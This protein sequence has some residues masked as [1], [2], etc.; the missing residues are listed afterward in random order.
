M[1]PATIHIL[2]LVED[3]G[4]APTPNQ[5]LV[6][7]GRVT[8]YIATASTFAY[9]C[10][11][12][13]ITAPSMNRH[14]SSSGYPKDLRTSFRTRSVKRSGSD[15][16]AVCFVLLQV[17]GD[18]GGGLKTYSYVIE[19]DFGQ[20]IDGQK[21]TNPPENPTHL[22]QLKHHQHQVSTTTHSRPFP[23]P[24]PH[25][26]LPPTNPYLT[27]PIRTMNAHPI[28]KSPP[29]G[30]RTSQSSRAPP[31]QDPRT[32]PESWQELLK[33]ARYDDLAERNDVEGHSKCSLSDDVG[34]VGVGSIE[35][36]LREESIALAC[37]WVGARWTRA[38][39]RWLWNIERP[40]SMGEESPESKFLR[41]NLSLP[42]QAQNMASSGS[43]L[44]FPST[45]TARVTEQ[46]RTGCSSLQ[47]FG[48][49]MYD[50]ITILSTRTDKSSFTTARAHHLNSK[51]QSNTIGEA[52][53]SGNCL[54]KLPMNSMGSK[55]MHGYR[56]SYRPLQALSIVLEALESQPINE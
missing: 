31:V 53:N 36:G 2:L 50:P 46:R 8:K 41:F 56:I 13:N 40:M 42:S 37:D 34:I 48:G 14:S 20:E 55:Y 15:R 24:H 47:Q 33:P 4:T 38:R 7:Q 54:S 44:H 5:Y 21:M 43:L 32:M 22:H 27:L 9:A 45:V 39:V 16:E 12:G 30:P 19:C 26:P 11:L 52:P 3:H 10:H 1:P 18:H 23:H 6:P 25:P 49:G 29:H 28:P 35:G 17:W 51:K